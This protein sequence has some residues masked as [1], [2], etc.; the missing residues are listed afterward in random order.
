MPEHLDGGS[1]P[2]TSS[3]RKD[4]CLG[5]FVPRSTTAVVKLHEQIVC[6]IVEGP[7]AHVSSER[8]KSKSVNANI[9]HI[10]FEILSFPITFLSRWLI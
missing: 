9:T 5:L 2:V 4:K 1:S 10:Q 3:T 8:G 7:E 6:N